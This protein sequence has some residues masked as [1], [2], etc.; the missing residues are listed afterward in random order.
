MS[1]NSE[2]FNELDSVLLKEIAELA[3]RNFSPSD[4]ALKLELSKASFM[5][6]WRDK[7]SAIR[8]AYEKGR[9]D[10][11]STKA[12]K[13]AKKVKKGSITAIQMHDKKEEESHFEAIKKEIFGLE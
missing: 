11:A 4:I 2:L 8:E 10:I 7:T 3:G 6:V 13:I 12:K 5:H 9:L 1:S